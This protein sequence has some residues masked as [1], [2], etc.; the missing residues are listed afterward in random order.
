VL[1]QPPEPFTS[2]LVHPQTPADHVRVKFFEQPGV[3]PFDLFERHLPEAIVL[4]LHAAQRFGRALAVIEEC[5][6]EIEE[7]GADHLPVVTVCAWDGCP[8]SGC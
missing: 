6:V 3:L 2:R 4:A 7:N 5:V 1:E 8:P